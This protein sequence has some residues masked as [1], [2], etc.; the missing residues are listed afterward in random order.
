MSW[1]LVA[2]SA[3]AGLGSTP[4]EI[5][6][7]L[8]AGHSSIAPLRAF[9][10]GRYRIRHAYEIDD[11]AEPG[12]DEPFR[13]TRWLVRTVDDALREAG[14]RDRAADI[15]VLVGTTLRESRSGEL[16]WRDGI[17]LTPADLHF[18][19]ALRDQL[20]V[21][22]TETTASA[23]AAGLYAL[24]LGTD[25]IEAGVTDTVVVAATD[26]ITESAFGGLDRVQ[27]PSPQEIRP[28]DVDRRGMV[29]GEGAVALVL[30]KHG[31]HDGAVHAVVR[32]VEMNCDAKHP[33][34]PDAGSV[35]RAMRHA[36]RRSGVRAEDVD[37][38]IVHGSGTAHNDLA[39]THALHEVFGGVSPGPWITSIK[40][41]A[42]HTCGGSGLLSLT[43]A[44]QGLRHG[45]VPPIRKLSRPIP[46]AEGLRLVS[47]APATGALRT[48]Q[49]NAI[50]LGGINAVA[51]VEAA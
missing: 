13:A 20:G 19:Q 44:V 30:R 33:T 26:A 48:A 11:R 3:I 47:G 39:E 6:R 41:G 32:G 37:F 36:H 28:F 29:M 18:A 23:C 34:V 9:D 46:E 51:I 21:R 42:G 43:T 16:W 49:I 17:P 22:R 24:G 50:G 8:C 25:L 45:A 27:Y 15:P 4:A 31:V 35:A 10:A 7:A 40:S 12:R 38:V 14:L 1:D 5:Y 2:M